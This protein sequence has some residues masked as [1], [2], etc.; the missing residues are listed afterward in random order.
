MDAKNL[1]EEAACLPYQLKVYYE[2]NVSVLI[3]GYFL[4]PED[5]YY[6]FDFFLELETY[7]LI[8]NIIER[9]DLSTSNILK[10]ALAVVNNAEY[11]SQRQCAA[12]RA[13]IIDRFTGEAVA[14]S[15]D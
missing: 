15:E 8:T 12:V 6:N 13:E 7:D 9:L 5:V 14:S 1:R 10:I 3:P 4:N 2:D 11:P